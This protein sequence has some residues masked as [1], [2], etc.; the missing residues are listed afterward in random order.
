MTTSGARQAVRDRGEGGRASDAASSRAAEAGSAEARAAARGGAAG[1]DAGS[2]R[3][4]RR[5]PEGHPSRDDSGHL[6][7]A[8]GRRRAARL[9]LA[10]DEGRRS[11]R[12][13]HLRR[14]R[15]AGRADGSAA[16][17]AAGAAREL[18]RL[19]ELREPG[20]PVPHS[21]DAARAAPA[22]GRGRGSRGAARGGRRRAQARDRRAPALRVPRPARAAG[23]GRGAARRARGVRARGPGRRRRRAHRRRRDGRGRGG[24]RGRRRSP[25]AA[26]PRSSG[27]GRTSRASSGGPRALHGRVSATPPKTLDVAAGE[28]VERAAGAVVVARDP[29]PAVP[30]GS[31]AEAR[32][33]RELQ[34]TLELVHRDRRP[35]RN[36]ARGLGGRGQAGARRGAPRLLRPGR[37]SRDPGA[38][39]GA[40]RAPR[41]SRSRFRLRSGI[42]RR[43][44]RAGGRRSRCSKRRSPG[45]S[46]TRRGAPS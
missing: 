29:A 1:R 31:R 38:G 5:V 22:Q 17:R 24:I 27:R 14:V 11:G 44:K 32:G 18:G 36:R 19:R 28:S 3:V 35:A 30:A 12:D 16:G 42:R 9:G 26:R 4:A 2:R 13:P 10:R 20:R 39:G 21:G 37:R 33:S 6:R 41:S 43:R 46:R 7:V 40:G 34:L 23:R 45:C 25:W 8:Q 15:Q